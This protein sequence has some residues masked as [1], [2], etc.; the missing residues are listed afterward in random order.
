MLTEDPDVPEPWREQAKNAIP[1]GVTVTKVP[2]MP[3]DARWGRD[4]LH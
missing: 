3:R 4:T 2:T 1:A